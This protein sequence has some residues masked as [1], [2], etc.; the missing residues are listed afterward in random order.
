MSETA[1][2]VKN[3]YDVENMPEGG[4]LT[5]DI[6]VTSAKYVSYGMTRKDGSPVI[7]DKTKQQA[8]FTGL[9]ITAIRVGGEEGKEDKYEFSAGQKAKPSPDGELLLNDKGEP[10]PIYKNSNL[11]KFNLGLKDCKFP[12]TTLYPRVSALVGAK[13]T[14]GGQDQKDA[15]G[16]VKTY[17]GTDKKVHN[18]IEWFPVAYNGGAGTRAAAGNG[19]G[20]SAADLTDK[21]EAAVVAAIAEAGGSIARKD[22]IRALGTNL[23]G[24]ADAVRITALVAKQD[25]HTGRPWT[26]DGSTLALAEA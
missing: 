10:A 5:R 4:G 14:M 22:L 13:L 9:R 6:V 17:V 16:K 25:F 3:P 18:S 2:V 20:T 12:T 21:A 8:V 24:D 11:G 23:K 26:F 19:A 1:Q 15:N 7:N